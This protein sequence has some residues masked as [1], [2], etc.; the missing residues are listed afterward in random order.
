M[1]TGKLLQFLVPKKHRI[2]QVIWRQVRKP[3]PCENGGV[4]YGYFPEPTEEEHWIEW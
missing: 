4:V 1:A 2:K 3:I